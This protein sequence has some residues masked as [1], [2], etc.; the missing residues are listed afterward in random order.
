MKLKLLIKGHCIDEIELTDQVFQFDETLGDDYNLQFESYCEQ[1]ELYTKYQ[2][3]SLK[4][5]NQRFIEGKDWEIVLIAESKVN[6]NQE[7]KLKIA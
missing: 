7:S 5:R 4:I 2:A 3:K 6:V 1:R